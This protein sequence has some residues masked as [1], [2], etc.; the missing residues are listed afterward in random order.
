[1]AD[2][3]IVRDESTIEKP[4]QPVGRNL[5][6]RVWAFCYLSISVG[7]KVIRPQ[8]APLVVRE[9]EYFTPKS[10]NNRGGKALRIQILG[11]DFRHGIS[12]VFRVDVFAHGV[13]DLLNLIKHHLS[14][15]RVYGV[16]GELSPLIHVVDNAHGEKVALGISRLNEALNDL[17]TSGCGFCVLRS[18]RVLSMLV[19]KYCSRPLALQTRRAFSFVAKGYAKCKLPSMLIGSMVGG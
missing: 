5:P 2:A 15:H 4:A 8:M 17:E 1:M 13:K 10:I 7:A 9:D 6:S 18:W 14:R 19:H 12:S 16:H 3:K 11:R